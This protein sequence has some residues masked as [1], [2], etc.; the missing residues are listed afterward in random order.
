MYRATSLGQNHNKRRG[1]WRGSKGVRVSRRWSRLR[2]ALLIA[3]FLFAVFPSFGPPAH[4]SPRASGVTIA[5][6]VVQTRPAVREL[7]ALTRPSAF[8]AGTDQGATGGDTLLFTSRVVDAGQL[9]DRIG[10]H[11]IAGPGA[12]NSIYV[13]MRVS[14]DGVMWTDW[15][16]LPHD[17]DMRNADRNEQF[18]GPFAFP[19]SRY[20]Q[21]RT[22]LTGGD[23]G[24]LGQMALTFMDVSDV[25]AG[26]VA[27]LVNDIT[28][29]FA[30]M[31]NSYADAAPAGAQKIL[32]RQDWGADESLMKWAPKYQRVQKADH[33][34]HRHR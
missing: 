3:L 21:Y 31:W 28:G 5:N 6:E 20:A 26:P 30:D 8:P 4:A 11:W 12:E 24:A 19:V 22:W 14:K 2:L 27:Q 15:T 13:E 17:E 23:A 29:A 10:T 16:A 9:F 1:A 33:P 7:G 32:T 18:A 34:P 25:N